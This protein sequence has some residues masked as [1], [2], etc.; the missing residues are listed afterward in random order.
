MSN[1][2]SDACKGVILHL[3]IRE[4]LE[5]Y[6]EDIREVTIAIMKFIT[7]SLGLQD[8]QISE[9]FREGLYDI[10]M[11]CYPPCPEPERVLGIVP[12]ADN[13]GIT[14]LLDC[15]DFSGLQFLREEKWVNVEPIEGAIVVNI[16]Q[17][18]EVMSNGIYKAPEHRAVVNKWKES[19]DMNIGP[20]DE[21][22]GEGKVA[23]YKKL[24]NAEYFSKFFNRKLDESF[25]DMLRI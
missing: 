20:A 10:R 25:V 21:L 2:Y 18:I 7:M 13:S 16:G 3:I 9:S 12:H 15:A 23:V 6:S 17:I 1:L 4:T 11:N 5:R 24:T 8:T 19:P 22:I 14:L